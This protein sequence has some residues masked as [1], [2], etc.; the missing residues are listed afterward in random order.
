MADADYRAPF[1]D[2]SN[3]LSLCAE[4]AD[5]YRE[6]LRAHMLLV[7]LSDETPLPSAAGRSQASALSKS[8]ASIPRYR[9][10]VSSA[11]IVD[12]KAALEENGIAA[13]FQTCPSTG[14]M[15][16]WSHRISN[17]WNAEFGSTAYG[18]VE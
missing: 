13:P 9:D 7:D 15:T 2:R 10:P 5:A 11:F 16:M 17:T 3:E 14:T 6:Q 8:W 1:S 4:G 18:V 12:D